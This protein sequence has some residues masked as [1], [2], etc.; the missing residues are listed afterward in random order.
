MDVS[1]RD[2]AIVV[3]NGPGNTESCLGGF[4]SVERMKIVLLLAWGS[5]LVFIA[6]VFFAY[7]AVATVRAMV[8]DSIWNDARPPRLADS[9]RDTA[10]RYDVWATGYLESQ[11]ATRVHAEDVPATEWPIFG[12]VFLLL[13]AEELVAD[14]SLRLEGEARRAVDRA[15]EV[16]AHPS[17]ASWVRAKWGE[18]YLTRENVFYRMLLIMGLTSHQ[19]MTGENRYADIVEAQTRSLGEELRS[20]PLHLADDYP[21]ECYPNDVL[22]AVAAVKRAETCGLSGFEGAD[23]LARGLIAT[24]SGPS[25]T[26]TGMPAFAVEATT[27]E[28]L[29]TAR[30]S[31]NSGILSFAAEL[32]PELARDWF[33]SYVDN[34]WEDGFV[35]GFREYP[36]GQRQLE[37]VDSGP[38]L[39]GVGSVAT[40]FGVGAA[41]SV[42]RLDHAVP[43]AMET[44]PASWP[45]PFGLLLPGALGWMAAD[46]WCFGELA[47]LFASTRPI[48]SGD[49]E[50]YSGS[51][52]VM[53]W[54]FLAF[55]AGMA[56][57]FAWLGLRVLRRIRCPVTHWLSFLESRRTEGASE[58]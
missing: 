36:H 52:P 30:G 4:A 26:E 3:E 28:P 8:S 33:Q 22:W 35:M 55:Y 32:D 51:I 19:R 47:L 13:S 16:V 56:F 15:A 43:L 53:V 48:R 10:A 25:M 57:V 5:A 12:S 7:P 27:G 11:R 42:G 2:R 20:R 39:F 40:G 23:E 44:V 41:R 58:G 6:A 50:S 14:G 54:A 17:T 38:I 29:Q 9:F 21:G 1:E 45:T 46:G 18:D 24:L 31:G 37:D 34:F 49:V